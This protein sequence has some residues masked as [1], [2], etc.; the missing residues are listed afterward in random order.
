[1]S[2]IAIRG[3]SG[4]TAGAGKLNLAYRPVAERIFDVALYPH[5]LERYARLHRFIE[6]RLAEDIYPEHPDAGHTRITHDV[7]ERINSKWGL[8]GMRVLDVGCGQGVAL[9]KFTNYGA[10][11][12]GLAFGEDVGI[13]RKKGFDVHEMDMSFLN[14][15]DESFDLVWARH[16]LEHSLFPFFTVD[17]IH[18]VLKHGGVLYAE[19][20]APDT[21]ANHQQNRN[22][23]SCHT[24]SS[25]ATL[26]ERVGFTTIETFDLEVDLMCG[27]DVWFSFTLQKP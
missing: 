19:V 14:F 11:V 13:C 5:P 16:S 26:F 21:S 2:G 6:R 12:Q 3:G 17:V 23:Y 7:L 24:R 8:R 22:H 1:M 27:P 10:V 18:S 20:P 25:W 15:P 9:E 4:T